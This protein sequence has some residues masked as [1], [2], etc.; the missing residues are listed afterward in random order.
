MSRE[1]GRNTSP[2]YFSRRPRQRR[3]I[4]ILRLVYLH[5]LTLDHPLYIF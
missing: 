3:I 5:T 2:P 1:S 4:V